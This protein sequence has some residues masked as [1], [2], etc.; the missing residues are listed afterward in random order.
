MSLESGA[1]LGPYEVLSVLGTGGMGEVYKARDSRLD[2]FVAIKTLRADMSDSAET[3]ERFEREARAISRLS[4]PHVCSVFDV[5]HVDGTAYLVMELIE[6]ETLHARLRKGPLAMAQVLRMGAEIADALAAAHRMGIVHRDLKPGNVMVTPS[7]VKLLDFGL[8]KG[9][10]PTQSSGDRDQLQTATAQAPLTAPGVWLG[11]APYMAPEQLLGGPADTRGD[12]FALGAVLYEMTAGRRAFAGDS[13]SAIAS[14]IIHADPPPVSS[15]RAGVP[16]ELERLI[17]QC[18]AKEPDQRWQAAHDAALLL[19]AITTDVHLQPVASERR[20]RGSLLAWAVAAAA[21][22]VALIAG[23]WPGPGPS[24]S[25]GMMTLQIAPAPETTFTYTVEDVSFALSPDGA[26]L[27]FVATEAGGNRRVWRRRLD[28]IEAAPIP[29]TEGATSV[30]WSPDSRSIGFFT[31]DTLK[32]LDLTTGVALPV[33]AIARSIGH[34]G[35][36]GADGR[37]LFSTVTGESIYEVSTAGGTPSI[38]VNVDRSRDEARVLFPSFLADGRRYLY[39]VRLQDATGW[40]MYVEPGRTARRL[41]PVESNVGM[42]GA[43]HLAFVQGGTLVAQGFDSAAGAMLGEPVA[44]APVVRFFLTTAAATFATSLAG[45]LVYQSQR[46]SSRLAWVDRSGRRV[47]T[48]G[49]PGDYLD[50]RLAQAGRTVLFSRALPNTGTYDVWSRDL[51]RGTETRVTLDDVGTEFSPAQVPGMQDLIFSSAHGR[52]PR[53]FRRSI[54]TGRV[55]PLVADTTLFQNEAD[56]SGDGR[57]ASYSER[58]ENGVVS[59]WT[60]PLSGNGVP[61]KRHQTPINESGMRFAPDSRHYSFMSTESGRPEIYVASM[62]GGPKVVVSTGGGQGAR[63][64]GDGREIYYLSPDRHMMSVSVTLS[65]PIQLATPAALFALDADWQNYDV[66]PDGTRF[67]SLTR[68]R[69]ANEQPLTAIVNW[70]AP[71][72]R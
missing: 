19:G 16:P 46:D 22:V 29:G 56:V 13:V 1:R 52:A 9:V 33:S 41:R 11:T 50:A 64:R 25:P 61:S 65:T 40:L 68:E 32:R 57:L 15:V 37:I 48:V 23:L 49:E 60:I 8:A 59:L 63:W 55:T 38:L 43:G 42:L 24:V 72:Q 27:A 17:H 35:T 7:G 5:G 53:L 71:D 51:A 14:A 67:L 6:G 62:A 44:V 39:V 69:V 4:H 18:L 28:S 21:I 3:R 26:N 58:D 12:V 31:A 54:E 66:S 47:E 2:R 36:W 30:F 20:S 34:S 10:E 45:A 70:R